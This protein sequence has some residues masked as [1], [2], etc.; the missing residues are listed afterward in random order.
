MITDTDITKLKTVFAT[1]DDLQAM[2]ARQDKKYATKN[3]LKGELKAMEARQDKKYATKNEL[4]DEL[5]A[6]EARLNRKFVTKDD[7]RITVSQQL[8]VEKPEWIREI[9]ESVVHALGDKIDKMYV[10]LDSFI[11]DIKNKREIQEL[12]DGD[13]TRIN[14]RLETLE[15][16]VGISTP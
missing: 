12:H 7:I 10:K 1:K 2:E 11:G 3:E 13:H 9:T 15:K 4:K 6:M 8:A 14:D 16:H 5:K